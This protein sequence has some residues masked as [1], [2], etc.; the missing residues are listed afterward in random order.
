MTQALTCGTL[1]LG[2]DGL[3]L[4]VTLSSLLLGEEATCVRPTPHISWSSMPSP[5]TERG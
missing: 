5:Q 3:G 1:E 4:A 2:E